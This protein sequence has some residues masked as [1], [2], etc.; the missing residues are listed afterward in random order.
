[1]RIR[2]WFV[3][4]VAAVFAAVGYAGPRLTPTVAALPETQT[5]EAATT[6]PASREP[7]VAEAVG[8]FSVAAV[9]FALPEAAAPEFPGRNGPQRLPRVPSPSLP[10]NAEASPREL[11]PGVGEVFIPPPPAPPVPD[12]LHFLERTDGFFPDG[13]LVTLAALESLACANNPTLRQAQAEVQGALGRAIQAGL[14][15]NPTVHYVQEQIDVNDR[16]GEFMGG[17]VQQE[18]VTAHKRDLSRAKYLARTETAEWLALAQQYR[19]LNDV[20]IHYFRAAGRQ[21]I[22]RIRQELLKNA[23]DRLLTAREMYN[24][25][26]A[27]RAEVH[28]ANVLLQQQRLELLMAENHYRT[29]WEEL[30]ALIGVELPPAMLAGPL[31]GE[32]SVVAWDDAVARLMAESPELGAARTKLQADQITVKR[33]IVEP[34]P[35][36]FVRGGVGHNFEATDTVGVAE[37]FVELPIYDWNQGTIRQAEADLVRQQG[38][39]RRTELILRRQLAQQYRQYLTALQH[40]QSFRD[41]ILPESRKAYELLLDSYEDDRVAWPIVL[42]AQRDYY[43]LQITY[44]QNLVAWRES[45]VLIAGYLLHNGLA[46]PLAPTP[47]AHIDAV[48]QPR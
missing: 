39:I 3:F 12:D 20:R 41:V 5:R 34:V 9:Q 42:E 36:I 13:E 25:G 28:Q 46:P 45:E 16:P 38:E 14:W 30:T 6:A 43:L 8:R 7:E 47:P 48:P 11:P 1:M 32:L 15:P 22:V 29:A 31:E 4:P 27:T 19:V 23:E 33:E 26:Q 2:R 44:V 37:V 40:V 21:E 35:N 18:I 24:V 17:I 10:S